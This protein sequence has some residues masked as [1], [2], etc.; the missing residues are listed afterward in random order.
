MK[1]IMVGLMVVAMGLMLMSPVASAYPLVG[2]QVKFGDGPGT[3]NGGEFFMNSYPAGTAYTNTFCVENGHPA[4][5]LNFTGVFTVNAYET[6]SNGAAYLYYH[7]AK[8]DLVGYDY[9]G[10]N[11]VA[12]ANALQEAIWAFQGQNN[13]ST[14]NAFYSA[15]STANAAQIAEA[16]QHVVILDMKWANGDAAQDV[17]GYTAVPEPASMILFGLGLLGLAGLRRKLKK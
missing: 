4:E 6:A 15:G 10:A 5:Y 13:G 16:Q 11:H 7:F 9:S 14:T 12:S 17:L 1:K 8:G 2:S 3:T